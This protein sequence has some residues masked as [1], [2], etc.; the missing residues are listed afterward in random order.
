MLLMGLTAAFTLLGGAGTIC[1]A[2]NADQYG[3]AF[4]AF[5]PNMPMYQMFVYVNVLLAMVGIVVTY[6]LTR[7]YRWA[8]TGALVTLLLILGMAAYQMFFSS[9]LKQ[10]SFF[11]TAP[12]SMRFYVT[13]LTLAMFLAVKLPG[14]RERVDFTAPWRGQ[15]SRKAT[16]GLTASI[17]GA[18]IITT[19]VWAG[20][21]HTLNGVNLANIFEIP[22]TVGGWLL[23]LLGLGLLVETALGI[24]RAQVV[25]LI[26]R[27]SVFFRTNTVAR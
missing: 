11:D 27:H 13:F 2:W 21:S 17:A 12:T 16:G 15:G 9:T 5:V 4:A 24:T 25:T 26:R 14:I 10:T 23:V 20:A 19:P 1:V 7:G 8:Y 22:L 18:V 3:P 6:A